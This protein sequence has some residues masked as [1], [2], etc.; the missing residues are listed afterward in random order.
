[1]Y[2][3]LLAFL[4]T[5]IKLNA[6]ELPNIIESDVILNW[7]DSSDVKKW[8]VFKN[9]VD[10][11]SEKFYTFFKGKLR[12]N[13]G[14]ARDKFS[15]YAISKG[16]IIYIYSHFQYA[17]CSDAMWSHWAE[18]FGAPEF[19]HNLIVS[20]S[21]HST[22]C[23]K[24]RSYDNEHIFLLPYFYSNHAINS[25]LHGLPGTDT[26]VQRMKLKLQKASTSSDKEGMFAYKSSFY[27]EPDEWD[28]N[29]WSKRLGGCIAD[30]IVNN[31]EYK[32]KYTARSSTEVYHDKDT[33]LFFKFH[34]AADLVIAKHHSD[35]KIPIVSAAGMSSDH[36]TASSSSDGDASSQGTDVIAI[37]DS[38]G[39]K[40]KSKM[41]P[42]VLEKL[43]ELVSNIHIL[44]VRKALKRFGANDM[45]TSLR[46]KG[47]LLSRGVGTGTCL[48]DMPFLTIECD[49]IIL[50]QDLAT[51][52]IET[53][54]NA[55]LPGFVCVLLQHLIDC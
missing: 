38:I 40:D 1:M 19:Q 34:G 6:Q 50:E 37:E 46:M 17:R 53:C 15:R 29:H 52:H 12:R 48:Y 45:P 49:S 26:A 44:L 25:T 30:S 5:E 41:T 21:S 28:E 51:L 7:L 43:G 18:V 33:V 47:A 20:K 22:I 4:K 9:F 10:S 35:D 3:G 23:D 39:S 55:P 36:E 2:F 32:V 54:L 31:K 11:D 8:R 13:K 24:H 27:E 16:P 42:K 14:V